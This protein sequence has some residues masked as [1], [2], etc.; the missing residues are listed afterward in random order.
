MPSIH[1]M[2]GGQDKEKIPAGQI[3][4]F[5]EPVF[6]FNPND[7]IELLRYTV[8]LGTENW[9]NGQQRERQFDPESY[10]KEYLSIV[11]ALAEM[12]VPFRIIIAH[13]NLADLN[14]FMALNSYYGIRGFGIDQQIPDTV[15]PR[16]M[17]VDF[18]GTVFVNPNANVDFPT[19]NT[20]DSVL[21]EGGRVLKLGKKVLLPDPAPNAESRNQIL[22]H[23]G[24]L[25]KRF[26]VGFIP[27]PVALNIH[28]KFGVESAFTQ[29]HI[30]RVAAFLRGGDGKDYL[31]MESAYADSETPAMGSY[32]TRIEETCGKLDITPVVVDQTD[33]SIPGRM[34]MVQFA[35]NSVLMT[36]GDPA[37]QRIIEDVVGNNKVTATDVPIINYPL[38]RRGGIRCMTLFASEKIL[39]NPLAAAPTNPS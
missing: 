27:Y 4:L 23:A 32:R 17:L 26:Q 30:D 2:G 33:E 31:F 19:L 12:R 6:Q 16:D 1:E 37:L 34:N 28:P 29:S 22:N 35:D 8:P 25:S 39:G 24:K 10:K 38:F 36:G 3:M 11:D 13:R 5:S 21:G 9:L 20:R 14:F 15:F 7:A 18:D